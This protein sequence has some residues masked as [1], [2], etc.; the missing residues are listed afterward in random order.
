LGQTLSI[1][2]DGHFA[3]AQERTAPAGADIGK[4]TDHRLHHHLLAVQNLIHGY[5]DLTG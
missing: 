5:G 4:R 3:R 1:Q 2:N